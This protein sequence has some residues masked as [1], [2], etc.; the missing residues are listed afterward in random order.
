MER[1][2]AR[3]TSTRSARAARSHP[4]PIGSAPGRPTVA[5]GEQA[6]EPALAGDFEL[7][8]SKVLTIATGQTSSTGTVT[9][10]AVD[11]TIDAPD[12]TVTVSATASNS[13]GVVDPADV[14]LTITDDDDAPTITLGLRARVDPRVGQ[15]GYGGGRGAQ[16]RG[17]RE[18]FSPVEARRRP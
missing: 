10:T 9:I 11:N 17:D 8:T 15:R 18:P 12:K 4:D 6:V 16:D 14:T 5:E 13:V 7:S 2:S 1:R 3:R